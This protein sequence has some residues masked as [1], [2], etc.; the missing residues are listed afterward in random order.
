MLLGAGV[1]QAQQH[2]MRRP[3]PSATPT[4]VELALVVV[5]VAEIL[6]A[7]ES[8][9]VDFLLR[10]RWRD[11]RLTWNQSDDPEA[12]VY[13]Y[14]LSEVWHPRL[15]LIN[16]KGLDERVPTQVEVT[17]DGWVVY[18]QRF[19][20]LMSTPLA[21]RD[22]PADTQRLPISVVS[23]TN[24]PDDVELLVDEELVALLDRTPPA[25]W[26]LS[27]E[28]PQIGA[29]RIS[30]ADRPTP[31]VTFY[32]RAQRDPSYFLWTMML[33]LTL[34]VF[35]AWSVF[36]MDPSLL[37]PQVGISTA[38]VFSMIAYRTALRVTL[39]KVSYLTKADVFILGCTVLVF[40]ALAHV[41]A[42]GR[43][44][45]TDREETAHRMDR[46]GRWA[47]P[48]TYLVILVV[49]AQW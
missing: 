23:A 32:V 21:L 13:R 24:S 20:G 11:E 1:V 3:G 31:Q 5:E 10:A 25:G 12:S 40:F 34:I 47:Y 8:F 15:L 49:A 2:Q 38:A 48:I 46:I 9:A 44:A 17:P 7:D 29:L 16:D 19:H 18:R 36:W 4:R 22:F 30:P 33:P 42:A 28:D 35:M 41:V 14:R 27:M 6:D 43:Y 45:K 26:S 39:P 37:P